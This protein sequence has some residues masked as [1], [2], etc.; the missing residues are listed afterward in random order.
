LKNFFDFFKGGKTDRIFP[1]L[2]EAQKVGDK[3]REKQG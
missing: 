2:K 1:F 3:G